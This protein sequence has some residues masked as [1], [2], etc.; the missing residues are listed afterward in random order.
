MRSLILFGGTLRVTRA[1]LPLSQRM[2]LR[3]PRD[4]IKLSCD[5]V[6]NPIRGWINQRIKSRLHAEWHSIEYALK[7]CQ[8][9]ACHSQNPNR[10]GTT[11]EIRMA[12]RATSTTRHRFLPTPA[13][14]LETSQNAQQESK[15][16]AKIYLTFLLPRN[17]KNKTKNKPKAAGSKNN[18]NT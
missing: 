12:R 11:D 9:R 14:A 13:T 17:Q 18:N 6:V 7:I 1:F 5:G 15:A 16:K 8:R 10:F 2:K 4:L 3:S